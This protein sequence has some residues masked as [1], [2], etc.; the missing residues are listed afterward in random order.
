MTNKCRG[1][2]GDKETGQVEKKWILGLEEVLL[3]GDGIVRL[4]VRISASPGP[5]SLA[6]KTNLKTVVPSCLYATTK[7]ES[8]W[9]D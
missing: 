5:D 7:P 6:L 1:A 9:S 8:H 2:R 3:S 4:E